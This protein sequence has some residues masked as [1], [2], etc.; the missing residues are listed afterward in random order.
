MAKKSSVSSR[1][2]KRISVSAQSIWSKPLTKKQKAVLGQIAKRQ[3][4]GDDCGIDYSDIPA[5]TEAQ[6]KEFYRPKKVAVT[7][8]LD[9]DLVAWMRASGRGY[10]TRVNAYLREMMRQSRKA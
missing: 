3:Q 8:R 9:A 6:L 7:V 2:V 10:Q 5:L 1:P 4:A